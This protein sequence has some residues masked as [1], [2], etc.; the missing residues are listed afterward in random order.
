MFDLISSKLSE[1]INNIQESAIR[2]EY[3]LRFYVQYCVPSLR[4]LLTVHELTGSQLD[5]LD[6]LHTNTIK[7]FLGL[8]SRGPTPA[9]IHSPYGLAIPRLSEV[10]VE[11]H[12]LAFA[13]SMLKADDRVIHALRS[14]ISR[15]SQWKRKMIKARC[16]LLEKEL[17]NC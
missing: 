13:R 4:Y 7:A 11:S 8:P 5:L 15:E 1:K 14:K 10:Y 16:C 3:K 6:H 12:T 17:R 9:I 2:D